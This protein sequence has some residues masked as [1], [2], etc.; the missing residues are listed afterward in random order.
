MAITLAAALAT[1]IYI[2]A[3]GYFSKRAVIVLIFLIVIEMFFLIGLILSRRLHLPD[4]AVTAPAPVVEQIPSR[5]AP[6]LTDDMQL[7]LEAAIAEHDRAAQEFDDATRDA[8][9][10]ARR[11]D[12]AAA[13][14]L[15]NAPPR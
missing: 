14:Y 7:R 4:S 2:N 5:V 10:A 11:Y 9:E 13:D 12:A 8:D 6:P 15:G 3:F 1:P